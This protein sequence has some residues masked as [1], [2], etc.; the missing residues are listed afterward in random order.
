MRVEETIQQKR[1]RAFRFR[2]YFVFIVILFSIL[3]FKVYSLQITH[4]EKARLQ[5]ENYE[6]VVVKKSIFNDEYYSSEKNTP[7]EKDISAINDK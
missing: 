2:M 5:S 7:R 4:G 3:L 1:S 6:D